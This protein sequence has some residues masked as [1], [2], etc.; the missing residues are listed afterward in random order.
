M[1]SLKIAR[2]PKIDCTV[3]VGGGSFHHIYLQCKLWKGHYEYINP[4]LPTF[5]Q[6]FDDYRSN[7]A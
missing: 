1:L 7:V 4:G 5:V 2:V 3:T 6:P